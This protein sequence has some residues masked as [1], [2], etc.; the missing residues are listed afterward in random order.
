MRTIGIRAL[1]AQL[2]SAIRDV[3]RGD[4][5]LVTDR[6]RVVAELRSPS[7]AAS[8]GSSTEQALERMAVEGRLRLAE[9]SASPYRVS[10][11]TSRAGLAREL[12]DADRGE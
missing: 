4:V 7:G 9:S 11:L 8:S 2:S 1:K 12:L 5:I 10:P 3:Q 6:G